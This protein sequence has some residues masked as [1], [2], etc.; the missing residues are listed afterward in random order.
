MSTNRD[1]NL[2]TVG[3]ALGLPVQSTRRAQA[4]GGEEKH[5]N[6]FAKKD[7]GEDLDAPIGNEGSPIEGD[8]MLDNAGDEGADAGVEAQDPLQAAIEELHSAAE[9]IQDPEV[10]D[11]IVAALADLTA[12]LFPDQANESDDLKEL[13]GDAEG[14]HAE[15]EDNTPESEGKEIENLDKDEGKE[16]RLGGL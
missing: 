2:R 15:P 8:A 3:Q 1:L 9:D 5:E 10:K 12:Q 14:D 6:P 13:Q 16:D 7:R 4:E 11:R